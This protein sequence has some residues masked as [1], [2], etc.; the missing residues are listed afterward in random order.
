MLLVILT[1][2]FTLQ[3]EKRISGSWIGSFD[4]PKPRLYLGALTLTIQSLFISP[5]KKTQT[6]FFGR[7]DSVKINGLTYDNIVFV[8]QND[9]CDGLTLTD[10]LLPVADGEPAEVKW[11]ADLT[12]TAADARPLSPVIE[13]TY[14]GGMSEE[15]ADTHVLEIPLSVTFE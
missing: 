7:I 9:N 14:T 3:P 10:L 1:M 2:Y 5:Q 8:P 15:T 4:S 12:F 6:D 11:R 13:I